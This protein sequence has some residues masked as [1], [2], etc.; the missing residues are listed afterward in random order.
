MAFVAVL[1][2]LALTCSEASYVHVGSN[3]AACDVT[4]G[5]RFTGDFDFICDNCGWFHGKGEASCKA[6][7]G[8][9]GCHTYSYIKY[10]GDFPCTSCGACSQCV[11]P[12]GQVVHSITL[13]P[14]SSGC[15]EQ[16]TG[17]PNSCR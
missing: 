17:T 5:E 12:P 8:T 14:T 3:A 2:V 9:G 16:C 10:S 6:T 15:D 11:S 13:E 7:A 4:L 1:V